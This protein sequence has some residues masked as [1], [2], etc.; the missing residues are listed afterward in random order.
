M[1]IIVR[2]YTDEEWARMEVGL[3]FVGARSKPIY[4]VVCGDVTIAKD[5]NFSSRFI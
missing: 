1:E 2:Q 5:L 3:R 4:S